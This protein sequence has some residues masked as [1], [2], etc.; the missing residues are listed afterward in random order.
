MLGLQ[1]KG[2]TVN[3]VLKIID[4]NVEELNKEMDET[5]SKLEAYAKA[6][7]IYEVR[8]CMSKLDGLEN[9]LRELGFLRISVKYM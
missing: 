1:F 8:S 4:D 9:T 5:Y 7:N 3:E 6:K 2:K